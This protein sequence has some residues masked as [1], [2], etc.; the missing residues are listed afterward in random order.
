MELE[1]DNNLKQSVLFN[2][3]S[4][5]SNGKIIKENQEEDEQSGCGQWNGT[6]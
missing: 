3:E 2:K 4:D 6:D 1:D 5:D